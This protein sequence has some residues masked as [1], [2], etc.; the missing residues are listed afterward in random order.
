[1]EVPKTRDSR[2]G[3][4]CGIPKTRDSRCRAA[5]S[6]P[7]TRDL[8]CKP[9]DLLPMPRDVVCRSP[10]GAARNGDP[11]CSPDHC[12]L[13]I[14]LCDCRAATRTCNRATP[15]FTMSREDPKAGN[16]APS[17][18]PSI[19]IRGRSGGRPA[20]RRSGNGES[21]ERVRNPARK[22]GFLSSLLTIEISRF[23]GMQRNSA[24]QLP[25]IQLFQNIPCK[26]AP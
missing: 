10:M 2:C 26:S 15:F 9:P 6:L 8:V 24:N 14:R 20:L 18:L 12:D 16:G 17:P 22:R 23:K 3:A 25:K 21:A 1:M 19:P 7:K 5:R 4:T 13:G 11:S